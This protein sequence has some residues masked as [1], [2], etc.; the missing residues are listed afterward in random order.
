MFQ[1]KLMLPLTCLKA[2]LVVVW[3][4][5]KV[6]TRQ[7]LGGRVHQVFHERLNSD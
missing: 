7:L 2:L 1:V 6:G 5:L 3:T 4:E